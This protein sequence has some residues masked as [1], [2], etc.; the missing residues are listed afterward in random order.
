[1]GS[2][3]DARMRLIDPISTPGDLPPWGLRNEERAPLPKAFHLVFEFAITKGEKREKR[4]RKERKTNTA[5][6]YFVH[7]RTF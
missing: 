1:M 7:K 4:G 2:Y 3:R 5:M 6:I